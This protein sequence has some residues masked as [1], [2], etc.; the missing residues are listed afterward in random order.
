[1]TPKKK[2]EPAA[3]KAVLWPNQTE[4]PEGVTPSEVIP[5]NADLFDDSDLDLEMED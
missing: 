5:Q 3:D 1:M 2:V 4:I